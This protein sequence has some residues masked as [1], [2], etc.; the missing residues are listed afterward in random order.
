G[1]AAELCPPSVSVHHDA[2]MG[3]Q[4]IPVQVVEVRAHGA[5]LFARIGRLFMRR[6]RWYSVNPNS[7]ARDSRLTVVSASSDPASRSPVPRRVAR[8]AS[9]SP[10]AGPESNSASSVQTA[11]PWPLEKRWGSGR[12]QTAH[13]VSAGW[14]P[15]S[16]RS[17]NRKDSATAAG[18]AGRVSS[19]RRP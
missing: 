1:Q 15:D 2:H 5:R 7:R 8:Y 6:S 13:V 12:P 19:A 18:S 4:A 10:E 11:P 16:D 9:A 3:G 14:K 17:F